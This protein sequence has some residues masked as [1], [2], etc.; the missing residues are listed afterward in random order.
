MIIPLNI[1]AGVFLLC[2]GL[3]LLL[4][5]FLI[6]DSSKSS[7]GSLTMGCFLTGM[8]TT[9][10]VFL[11]CSRALCYTLSYKSVFITKGA[12]P[13]VVSLRHKP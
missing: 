3:V 9:F 6:E 10:V 7:P 8:A 1:H 12:V 13:H 5:A 2:F 11:F 4:A